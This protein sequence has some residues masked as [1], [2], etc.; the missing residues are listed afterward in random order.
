MMELTRRYRFSASHRL[1]T[2]ELSEAENARLFGKCNNPFGHG[3]DY[4]LSVT[5]SGPVD[6]STGLLVDLAVLDELVNGRVVRKFSHRNL[7]LDIPQFATLVPTTE[8][9]AVVISGILEEAWQ[10]R[11]GDQRD[12]RL[13]RIHL[14]ETDRN[15]FEL[16]LRARHSG[17]VLLKKKEGVAVDVEG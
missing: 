7:N 17:P 11:F 16:D 1:H 15:G 3:H 5:V 6:A 10:A 13:T 12:L 9:V 4:V 14:Q 8:N 2:S